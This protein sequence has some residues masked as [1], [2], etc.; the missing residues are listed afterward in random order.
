[1]RRNWTKQEEQKLRELYK[2]HYS[3]KAICTVL[4]RS[5]RSVDSKIRQMCKKKSFKPN[6][7]QNEQKN[8]KDVSTCT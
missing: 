5:I 4:K 7:Y 1:M 3:I 2:G 6:H 8:H